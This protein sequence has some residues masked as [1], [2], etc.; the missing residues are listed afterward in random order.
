MLTHITRLFCLGLLFSGPLGLHSQTPLSLEE[1]VATALNNSFQ[2]QIAEKDLFI[3]QNNNH[4]GTAGRYPTV[5]ANINSQNGYTNSQNPANVVLPESTQLSTGGTGNLDATWVLYNGGRVKV[6]KK[7]LELLEQQTEIGLN[8]TIEQ[9]VSQVS[10]AYYLVLIQGEQLDVLEEILALSAD[11][12][13]YQKVRQEFGQAG[14]FDLLQAQDA[15]L[16]DSTNLI[17]QMN[18]YNNAVRNL[19]IA[20]GEEEINQDYDYQTPLEF[21]PTTYELDD[22]ELQLL[23]N[24]K[25]LQELQMARELAL[26]N[27][28][29][30]QTNWFP[31]IS[32]STG[33]TYNASLTYINAVNPFTMEEFGTNPGSSFNAYVNLGINYTIFNGGV[34][35]RNIENAQVQ[36]LQAQYRIEDLRR[37]L[38]G[39][40]ES[41]LVAYNEQ[42]ALLELTNAQIQTAQQN[43]D[44]AEERFKGGLISSFDYRAVQLSYINASQARLNNY[45][46]MKLAEI[47]LLQLV[48][49]I[50]Q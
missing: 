33:M 21:A 40:V 36:E 1:A 35:Q 50:A 41:Q 45:Y 42:K 4:W 3:A 13:N 20:M 18:A 10:Q 19:N 22:L 17:R 28:E 38:K 43:M 37:T 2:K 5:T 29:L 6:N 11:R 15:Y 12:V 24:N 9:V 32:V 48:G 46:N 27:T 23:G 8:R 34:R 31:S 14:S 39:Q 16:V 30:Q 26:V 25:D 49:A 44:L 47:N 7:Q